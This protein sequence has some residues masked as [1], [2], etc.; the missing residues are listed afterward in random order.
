MKQ[1]ITLALVFSGFSFT[2]PWIDC[3][4]TLGYFAAL[5]FLSG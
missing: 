4:T 2:M 5:I 1:N 3:I